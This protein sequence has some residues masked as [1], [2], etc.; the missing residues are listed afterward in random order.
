MFPV[1]LARSAQTVLLA[2]IFVFA[3]LATLGAPVAV[4]AAGLEAWVGVARTTPP[5]TRCR[6]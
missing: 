5:A 3:L 1:Q 4:V 6:A 2:D